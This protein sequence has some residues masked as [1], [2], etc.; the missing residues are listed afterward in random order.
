MISL[1][2]TGWAMALL[3]PHSQ[4]DQ[5]TVTLWFTGQ[6]LQHYTGHRSA[7]GATKSTASARSLHN[8]GAN[9][10]NPQLNICPKT[11]QEGAVA[12]V[13]ARPFGRLQTKV[14]GPICL[15]SIPQHLLHLQGQLTLSEHSATAL[16]ATGENRDTR[17]VFNLPQ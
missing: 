15:K 16:G 6:R 3:L 5:N 1:R 7:T 14:K 8:R 9:P 4:E 11:E 2:H 13:A 17:A 10:A 12:G